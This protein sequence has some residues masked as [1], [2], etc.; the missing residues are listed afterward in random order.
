MEKLSSSSGLFS[1]P[2]PEKLL[3][4]HLNSVHE[5]A[6]NKLEALVLPD[7]ESVFR[8]SKK[9]FLDILSSS[10][11]FHDF[12][13]ATR[14]FQ[15]YILSSDEI[16]ARLKNNNRKNHSALSA[17]ALFHYM[18]KKHIDDSS[19]SYLPFL[20]VIS[21]HSNLSNTYHTIQKCHDEDILKDQLSSIDEKRI[22]HLLK[23]LEIDDL[24]FSDLECITEKRF[25]FSIMYEEQKFTTESSKDLRNFLTLQFLFSLLIDSDKT[26][27]SGL[28][29]PERKLAAKT[30][31]PDVVD[32][33]KESKKEEWEKNGA[34][35]KLNKLRESLYQEL[36][37]SAASI[38][39]NNHIY[40]INAPTGSGKT[41]AGLNF[42][43]KLRNRLQKEKK[44]SPR[45]IY[46]LPF[47]SIIDQNHT[48]FSD[49]FSKA[50]KMDKIPD[51]IL[52]KHHHLSDLSFFSTEK[53]NHAA[54]DD[55]GNYD[56][57]EA[58][59][60]IE[61]WNSEVIVTTFHQFFHTLFG[62]RNTQL[63]KYH[64]MANSIIILDEIQS[65]P[66]KYWHLFREVAKAFCRMYN[67]YII[68]MTATIP[69]IFE[70]SEC[71]ELI[72]NKEKYFK[73]LSRI[74]IRPDF[75]ITS[76]EC[77][78][79]KTK[80]YQD[81]SILFVLNTI[82]S[83][84]EL[85]RIIESNHP[86]RKLF[87]LSSRITPKDRLNRIAEIKAY[88]GPKILVSTQLI[89]AGVDV[90]FDVVF[91]DISPLDSIIQAAGRCN[92]NAK[93]KSGQ[94]FIVSLKNEK[95]KLLAG[96]IYDSS[97]LDATFT[98]LNRHKDTDI[99]EN[100]ILELCG[101]YF[102]QVKRKKDLGVKYYNSACRLNFDGEDD[103]ISKFKLIET[104]YR[105]YDI[106]I[107][108]DKEASVVWNQRKRALSIS[109]RFERKAELLRLKAEF[110]NYVVS[111]PLSVIKDNIPIKDDETFYWVPLE[112]LDEFYS[113]ATGFEGKKGTDPLII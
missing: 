40:S 36:D 61:T 83:A 42:A 100:E 72:H 67:S 46:S 57:W 101:E 17:L 64:R 8:Y 14:F 79:E 26:D 111:V 86:E 20:A 85:M 82:K 94:V 56:I 30:L 11:K 47:L 71:L 37:V 76:I 35:I 59:A 49:V 15:D 5:Q 62:Y 113:Q 110:H 103:S 19:L 23:A 109:D 6:M 65:F 31:T 10:M 96:F 90:D 7:F 33:Y 112:N 28:Q 68:L 52:L 70:D 54:F 9:I 45:I 81:K 3:E 89:E 18:Q 63:R 25:H 87:F 44:F 58:K 12:G 34:N 51:D 107:E 73:S 69:G 55:E 98:I 93:G 91:R 60:L 1:H 77:L 92:R 38:D 32:K 48:V 29:L 102:E 66:P 27:A 75:Q 4:D 105:K 108:T 95:E 16:K 99:P 74:T 21:H 80:E 53:I 88:N 39:L 43:I 106:F 2:E 104:G 13:K 50:L 84:R 41:L 22:G 97:L 24:Q 78:A